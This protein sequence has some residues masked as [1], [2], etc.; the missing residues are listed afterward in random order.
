MKKTSQ[1]KRLVRTTKDTS[2]NIKTKKNQKDDIAYQ[3]VNYV[4]LCRP[5]KIFRCFSC[6]IQ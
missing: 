3:H 5:K 4:Q 1:F 6:A 2:Y